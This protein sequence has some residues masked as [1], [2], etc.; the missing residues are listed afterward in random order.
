MGIAFSGG[1]GVRD[2][3]VSTDNGHTWN[4][5][6]LE[7]DLGRYAWRQWTYP[8]RP[9]K[10]GKYTLM[11]R[12]ADSIGESQPFDSFWN[13]AGFMKNNIEKIEVMVK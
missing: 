1:Y 8:W 13:P 11:V 6:K 12:A 9:K 7:K 4:E 10:L 5:A 2:V 3:V